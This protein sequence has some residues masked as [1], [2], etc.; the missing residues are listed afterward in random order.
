MMQPID[1]HCLYLFCWVS[2]EVVI[3]YAPTTELSFPALSLSSKSCQSSNVPTLWLTFV[4]WT[5]E[6]GIAPVL[7]FQQRVIMIP[8]NNS[9][10]CLYRCNSCEFHLFLLK[11]GG[12]ACLVLPLAS[13]TIFFHKASDTATSTTSKTH[14]TNSHLSD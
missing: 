6:Q 7:C 2:C 11:H 4:N 10:V 9:V 12:V 3:S 8:T 5:S 1:S 14:L 13:H